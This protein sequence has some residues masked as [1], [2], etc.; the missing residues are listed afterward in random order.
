[1]Y[2]NSSSI[3]V[4]EVVIYPA[5]VS[6]SVTKGCCVYFFVDLTVS[7]IVFKGK[8]VVM[9]WIL[10]TWKLYVYKQRNSNFYE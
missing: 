6:I 9:L 2:K 5:H 1:M 8:T 4:F 7:K 3:K 10:E